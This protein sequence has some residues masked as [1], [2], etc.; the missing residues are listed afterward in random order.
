[1]HALETTV[2]H[3]PATM[4]RKRPRAQTTVP[5][6]DMQMPSPPNDSPVARR[7]RVQPRT[8]KRSRRAQD[9]QLVPD[10]FRDMLRED[11]KRRREGEDGSSAAAAAAVK[12]APGRPRHR[13][14]QK[15]DYKGKGKE[16]VANDIEDPTASVLVKGPP[17]NDAHDGDD[18][19]D[20]D[21][22]DDDD[23]DDQDDEDDEEGGSSDDEDIDWE[24]VDLGA[25]R[26]FGF[27]PCF[28][29]RGGEG[30]TEREKELIRL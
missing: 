27:L 20:G 8:S 24:D 22:N 18:D 25:K 16:V 30:G 28:P 6:P 1:M 17:P 7:T 29:R 15:V 4:P 11:L 10:V 2:E 19:H 13:Q 12:A 9:E 3:T 5:D 21:G 14:Q 26:R 23:H